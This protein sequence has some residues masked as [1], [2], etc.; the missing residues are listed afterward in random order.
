MRSQQL[1]VIEDRHFSEMAL[2]PEFLDCLHLPSQTADS[3]Q[4]AMLCLVPV[5]ALRFEGVL[6]A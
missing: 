2:M 6:L 4:T 1:K 3:L 5:N